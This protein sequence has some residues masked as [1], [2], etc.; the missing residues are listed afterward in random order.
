MNVEE[1]NHIAAIW[2]SKIPRESML[3]DAGGDGTSVRVRREERP[4]VSSAY[5]APLSLFTG[6]ETHAP[7]HAVSLDLSRTSPS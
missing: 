7:S 1:Q 5:D 6:V 4:R 2:H 3:V